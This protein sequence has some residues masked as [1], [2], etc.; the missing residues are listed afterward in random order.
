MRRVVSD[1]CGRLHAK[2]ATSVVAMCVVGCGQPTATE[3]D[4][5]VQESSGP[6][7]IVWMVVDQLVDGEDVDYES[8]L[9]E[10]VRVPTGPVQGAPAS[11]HSTLLTGIHPTSLGSDDGQVAGLLPSGVTTLPERL[12]RADY[13]TS[14][15]GPVLHNLSLHSFDSDRAYEV[16]EE[17]QSGLLG[18]W[19]TAGPDVDWRGRDLDWD[20]PCMVASGCARPVSSAARPFFSLFNMRMSDETAL[21]HTVS[22]ILTE[23]ETDGV[24]DNTAVFLVVL[25][26]ETLNLVVRWP[27]WVKAFDVPARDVNIVDLAPTVI[28][29]AGIAVPPYMDGQALVDSSTFETAHGAGPAKSIVVTRSPW[30]DGHP[31]TA[32]AP[33][34][35]PQGGQF[36]GSPQVEL[37]CETEG[38][39]IIYTTERAA[40]F[41]WRLYKGPFRMRFWTLRAKCGRLGYLDSNVT[42]YEFDH[43]IG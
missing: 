22:G 32:A 42:T 40:P 35:Y 37:W 7:N 33:E 24:V 43:D 15:S 36:H 25:G 17:Y 26:E 34:G 27:K 20:L 11:V 18:A 21:S 29:L 2:I 3:V 13:Y 19:D 1:W 5:L 39:T 23:L 8:L 38:A 41:H 10:G 16:A 14:R 9:K 4:V 28:A 31:P 30:S 12:R 6:A